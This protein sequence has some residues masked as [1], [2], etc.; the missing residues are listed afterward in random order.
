DKDLVFL[1]NEGNLERIS[2]VTFEGNTISPDGALK[3]KVQSKPGYFWYLFG[4]KVDG[5]KIDADVQMLTAYYRALGYFRARI[6]RTIEFDDSGKWATLKFTIDEGPQY[7]VREVTLEGSN[8]FDH[9]AVLSAMQ[10]KAGQSFNQ[11]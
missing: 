5:N 1:I 3:T 4:G 8:K 10:L 7:N 9:Q 6:S 2:S 11:A